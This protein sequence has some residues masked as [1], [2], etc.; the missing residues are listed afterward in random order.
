MIG[1]RHLSWLAFAVVLAARSSAVPPTP[2]PLPAPVREGRLSVESALSARR[3]VREF[4][5]DALTLAE[6]A[7]ILW[8]AQGLR[9]AEGGRT[10]PSAGALY[11]LEVYAVIGDV[12]DLV[13]GV[14][15]YRPQDHT[16]LLVTEGDRRA[17]VVDA[18]LAQDWIADAPVVVVIAAV[19]QRTTRKYGQRGQR[20]VHM[21]VGHAGEN[22][23]LQAVALKLGTTIVGAFNDD[24]LQ[25]LLALPED[26]RPLSIIPVGRPK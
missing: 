17:G 6:V 16:L 12:K 18:A 2:V 24:A 11:P 8:A 4:R 22:L 20:Y 7:Q 9:S 13:A 26:E 5:R 21:E 15:R 14:Y 25:K 10:A 1:K 3:S 23:C 19:Y